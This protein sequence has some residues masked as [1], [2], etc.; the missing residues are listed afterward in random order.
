MDS[1][2]P[3]YVFAVML[4]VG[5]L[6]FLLVEVLEWP[7]FLLLACRVLMSLGSCCLCL[8]PSIVSTGLHNLPRC[9]LLSFVVVVLLQIF[10]LLQTFTIGNMIGHQV[11]S[12]HLLRLRV[13]D[14][15]DVLERFEGYNNDLDVCHTE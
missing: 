14:L 9:R 6:A 1:K 13:A 12:S 4:L 15:E 5:N 11:M 3:F 10:N 8:Y 7:H 2:G